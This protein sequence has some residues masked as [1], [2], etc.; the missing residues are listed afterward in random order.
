MGGLFESARG[1]VH[2]THTLLMRKRR[3][4]TRALSYKYTTDRDDNNNEIDAQHF[5]IFPIRGAA[6][7]CYCR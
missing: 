7:P 2:M 6:I 1:A 3:R 5:N 4:R